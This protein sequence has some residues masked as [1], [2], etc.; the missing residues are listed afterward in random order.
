MTKKVSN[1]LFLLIAILFSSS[2]FQTYFIV[3][4]KVNHSK[5][6]QTISSSHLINELHTIC[7]ISEVEETDEDNFE[8]LFHCLSFYNSCVFNLKSNNLNLGLLPFS[9]LNKNLFGNVPIRI[10]L[11]IFRI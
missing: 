10:A 8:T 11:G 1:Y 3:S 4:S 2:I 7:Y 6:T 9:N 5:T